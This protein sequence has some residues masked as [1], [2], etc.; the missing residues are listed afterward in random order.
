MKLEFL[1]DLT[2][3]DKYINVVS[4]RMIR[5]YDFD[6]YQ[7]LSLKEVIEKELLGRQKEISLSSLD[8]V[9]ALNCNLTLKLS[10]IDRGITT[11]EN[12][13]FECYLTGA[14]YKKMTDLIEPFCNE[15]EGYQ[16]LYEINCPVDLLFSP[17]GTW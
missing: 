2:D 1:D 3:G 15:A 6:K 10:S 17:G 16:W 13:H 5:L 8:F 9:E 4:E 12:R 14:A 7:A 11:A